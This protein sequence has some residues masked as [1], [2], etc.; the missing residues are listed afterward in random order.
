MSNLTEQDLSVI[1]ETDIWWALVKD[2]NS[3]VY[4]HDDEAYL[5]EEILS[6]EISAEMDDVTGKSWN[7]CQDI[8][9]K[10]RSR[11]QIVKCDVTAYV[12]TRKETSKNESNP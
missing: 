6:S 3:I 1:N 5:D 7:E 11:Y 4:V 10:L 9:S 2:G 12:K 8:A